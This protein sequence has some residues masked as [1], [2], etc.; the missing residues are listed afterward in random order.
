MTRAPRRICLQLLG[1]QAATSA[2]ALMLILLGVDVVSKPHL[3]ATLTE[4]LYD[5]A[6]LDLC[7]QTLI[8]KKINK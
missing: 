7:I 8:L 2:Y 3:T 5:K 4:S 6:T 1:A